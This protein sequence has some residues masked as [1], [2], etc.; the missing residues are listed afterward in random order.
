MKKRMLALLTAMVMAF[1]SVGIA[2]TFVSQASD[3]TTTQTP[4]KCKK[5][6]KVIKKAKKC[7][8][9]G[10]T[11]AKCKKLKKKARKC[12]KTLRSQK[13][14][15]PSPQPSP[16]PS[17]SGG[18]GGQEVK[19]EIQQPAPYVDPN[20]PKV[21]CYSGKHRREA[22]LTD[23]ANQ[24]VDGWHFEV[25]PKT[26]GTQFLLTADSG[27]GAPDLDITFYNEFGT[28][29][30][31]ADPNYAPTSQGYDTRAAGGETGTVPQGMKLAIVCM[32]DGANASFTYRAGGQAPAPRPS[33]A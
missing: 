27:E 9:S 6:K 13:C 28:P 15:K 32:L 33:G 11:S 25:D 16:K 10:S 17:G 20:D 4:K 14:K 19:G 21:T 3:T 7:K 23:G 31:L 24:G 22:V 2:T 12:K 30:Q 29:E 26:L 5:C 1:A 8:K 18:T